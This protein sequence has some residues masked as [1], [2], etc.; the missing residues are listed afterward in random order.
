MQ[1]WTDYPF[2]FFWATTP[3]KKLRF[4]NV[5]L[6]RST[7]IDGV[8]LSLKVAEPKSKLGICISNRAD[9]ATSR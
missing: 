6:S 8:R 9:M 2:T 1:A 7:G 4:G 5:R 3:T